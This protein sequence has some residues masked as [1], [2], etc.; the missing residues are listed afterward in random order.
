MA[1]SIL[2]WARRRLW[3]CDLTINTGWMNVGIGHDAAMFATEGI[4]RWRR[5]M[6][7]ALYRVHV[8]CSLPPI[9]VEAMD[10]GSVGSTESCRGWPTT[11]S[12]CSRPAISLQELPSE[13]D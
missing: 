9:V 1:S 5:Q 12:S 10:I 4:R 8:V 11:P 13:T 7:E 2:N 6:S 3:G